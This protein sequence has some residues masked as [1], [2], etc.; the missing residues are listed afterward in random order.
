MKT[1]HLII[2]L[3]AYVVAGRMVMRWLEGGSR[4]L[5]LAAL[6]LG[7]ILCFLFYD[8]EKFSGT[9]IPISAAVPTATSQKPEKLQY[10][11]R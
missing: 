6:N 8:G 7:G 5:L 1:P 9:G 11:N 10:R 2:G 4:E 3:L